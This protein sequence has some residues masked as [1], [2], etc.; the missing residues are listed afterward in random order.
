MSE[1]TG[2]NYSEE[3][4]SWAILVAVAAW[5]V[6]GLGH[7]LL[8][9][10]GRALACFFAVGGL[11]LTGYLLRGNVFELHANDLRSDAFNFLVNCLG[12]LADLGS[13]IFYFLGKFLEPA[14]PDV[15]R[16]AG[17]HG[18][19]FIATAGVVNLLCVLDAY[20]IASGKKA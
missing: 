8:G 18:T 12:S 3:N 5:L 6:P 19:R 15:S 9:R 16:A 20:G 14:G 11:A 2:R 10:R 7:L 1:A 17:D 4:L 13:G